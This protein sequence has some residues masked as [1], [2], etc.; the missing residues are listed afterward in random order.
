[1]ARLTEK[2]RKVFDPTL[3]IKNQKWKADLLINSNKD[4]NVAGNPTSSP[5]STDWKYE[6]DD[7]EQQWKDTGGWGFGEEDNGQ[8]FFTPLPLVQGQTDNNIASTPQQHRQYPN[9]PYYNTPKELQGVSPWIIDS[10]IR[11]KG[12]EI[13]KLNTGIPLAQGE[14]EG[15]DFQDTWKHMDAERKTK[16][17][18]EFRKW[19]LENKIEDQPDSKTQANSLKIAMNSANIPRGDGLIDKSMNSAQKNLLEKY[20]MMLQN[21]FID[22]VEYQKQMKRLFGTQKNKK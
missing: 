3:L 9:A 19:Q 20:N 22:E 5:Y 4:T 12:L 7:I 6:G 16:F 10:F 14:G 15:V 18:K 13:F 1:M 21:G 8:G 17:L 11:D 2:E